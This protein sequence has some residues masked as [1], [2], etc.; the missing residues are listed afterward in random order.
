MQNPSFSPDSARLLF[1]N[2]TGGYNAGNAS[3]GVVSAAGGSPT[4]LVAAVA[5]TVDLPGCWNAALDQIVVSSDMGGDLDQIY[6]LDPAGKAQPKIVTTPG[7]RAWEPS[8]SPDGQWVVFE[9]HTPSGGN[10]DPGRIWKVKTDGTQATQLTPD[11][12]DAKEPNWSPKG[13]RILYQATGEGG[14]TDIFT[15]DP[16]GASLTNVTMGGTSE[17]TDASWSPDGSSIVYSSDLSGDS[18]S[19]LYV[20][21]STGGTPVRVTYGPTYD[22]APSWSPDGRCIAFETANRD[23]DG[24]P[25]STI[26]IVP[27][28]PR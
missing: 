18:L 28:P 21:P 5:Q 7:M 3:V 2:F 23:P 12:V 24:S 25:G 8:L 19:S 22:G 20:I 10:N 6:R 27:A 1:T 14:G 26:A 13:D 17:N 16:S 9:A 15:I 4:T 11:S